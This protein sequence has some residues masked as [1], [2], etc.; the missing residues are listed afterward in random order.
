MIILKE[1]LFVERS[2]SSD[3]FQPLTSVNSGVGVEVVPDIYCYTDQIVNVVFYGKQG[4]GEKWVLIDAGMPTS[5]RNIIEEAE[6]RFGAGNPPQAIILTHAHFDHIGGLIN[7]LEEW[8]VP[9]Y[10]HPLEIPYITGQQDY[11]DPDFMVEGGMVAK[12]SALFPIE[13]ID[14][15]N[16]ANPLPAD[17]SVPSMPGWKWIHT[18]GHSAGHVSFYRESDGALIAGDVFV[19]VRQDALYKVLTQEREMSGPPRYLT[20][21][22]PAAE[23]SVKAMQ[24]L[25]PKV[26]VTGH[27]VPV[28]GEWLE[29]NLTK[30]ADNFK[31]MAVPDY[32]KFV[33]GDQ[34]AE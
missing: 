2:S 20:P 7:V 33:D 31:E 13:A 34:P 22:W 17:N 19:T 24:A 12:M 14:I 16:R 3:R 23:Q 26:A 6:K 8:P 32:G 15:G 25:H 29:E 1:V 30:L 11:P 9:V 27:G 10:A 21:N 28:S 5:G 4:E 18:P